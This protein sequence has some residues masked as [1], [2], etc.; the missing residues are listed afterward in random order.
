V[1]LRRVGEEGHF[2][3]MLSVASHGDIYVSSI[4]FLGEVWMEEK[5]KEESS[6]VYMSLCL[7]LGAVLGGDD[8]MGLLP[9]REEEG[10]WLVG[11]R[12]KKN[13]LPGEGGFCTPLLLHTTPATCCQRL[14][15]EES[16]IPTCGKEACREEEGKAENAGARWPAM[17]HLARLTLKAK[18]KK[19][20]RKHALELM[21]EEQA[22]PTDEEVCSLEGRG[23]REGRRKTCA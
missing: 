18:K 20:K 7:P 2:P 9:L 11:R 10:E 22:V 12:R 21:K 15:E 6:V 3:A 13:L 4:S 16:T 5:R 14:K 17:K 19:E 1:W 8:G 23:M